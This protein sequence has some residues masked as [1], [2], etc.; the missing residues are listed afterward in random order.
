MANIG[1]GTYG[2]VYRAHDYQTKSA[3]AVKLENAQ[4]K[5]RAKLLIE[6]EVLKLLQGK[7]FSFIFCLRHLF[8]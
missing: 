2:T 5:S 4:R 3:V 8:C 1:E 7:K 6:S